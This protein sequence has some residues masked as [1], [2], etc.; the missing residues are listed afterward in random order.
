MLNIIFPEKAPMF[1]NFQFDATLEDTFEASIEL[2]RYPIE[3]GVYVND[4]RIINPKKWF[5]TG[6][7]GSKPL[8]PLINKDLTADDLIGVGIGAASNIFRDNPLVA[9]IA[10]LSI[11]FLAGSDA[12]RA[13]A[14]LEYL[15]G[16]MNS[17]VP[18]FVDAV[19]IQLKNMVITKISRTKDP[20]NEKGLIVTLDIQELIV[21][22]RIE[23]LDGLNPDSNELLDGD[24][25]QTACTKTRNRGQQATNV[26]VGNARATA[27]KEAANIDQYTLGRFPEQ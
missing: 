19:D 12:S 13:S 15:V 25:S 10:G 1:D 27:V 24:P 7:I 22:D 11:G 2:T 8:R 3:S 5:I 23:N 9:G 20:S 14:T 26:K 21:L 4:H 6:A 16:V 18:F 17:G